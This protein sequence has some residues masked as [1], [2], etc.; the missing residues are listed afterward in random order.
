MS[1]TTSILELPTDPAV[2]G[3]I[4]LNASEP[5]RLNNPTTP[6]GSSS[7]I[8]PVTLD[9]STINQ[10]ISGLQQ[11]S[12]SSATQ[13]PSRDIPRTT[14]TIMQD[15]QTQ[16]NYIPQNSSKKDYID[17][18][19]TEDILRAYNKNLKKTDSFNDSLNDAYNEIQN[20]LLLAVLYFL[21]QLPV[22]KKN[23]FTYIPSLF[24]KD[25]NYNIKGFLFTSVLFG[26]IFYKFNKITNLFNAF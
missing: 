18:E 3:N 23:L 14:D 5:L 2:G 7:N 9:E 12:T 20:P 1:E 24:S 6:G 15:A 13:L 8:P 19:N 25:G 4:T 16:P 22:F 11:A 17:E 26:F 10:I 21:F